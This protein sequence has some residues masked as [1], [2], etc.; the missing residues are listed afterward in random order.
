MTFSRHSPL[1]RTGAIKRGKGLRN[2]TQKPIKGSRARLIRDADDVLSLYVR[3]RDGRCVTCGR[4]DDLQA[5]HFYKRG[6]HGTR[7]HEKNVHAMCSDCN[8][9]HNTNVWPYTAFMLRTHGTEVISELFRLRNS[10]R[11]VTDAEIEELTDEYKMQLRK[12]AA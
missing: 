6:F 10:R 1:K 4:T 5:S 12:L 8:L 7:W 9:R 3:K 11:K 2:W